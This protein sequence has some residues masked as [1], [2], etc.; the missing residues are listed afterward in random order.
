MGLFRLFKY[1]YLL[2]NRRKR[3]ASLALSIALAHASV[4]QA[5]Y[6]SIG[7]G[8]AD[9]TLSLDKD[10]KFHLDLNDFAQHKRYKMA[11]KWSIENDY[12][13]LTFKKAK[14]DL[15][16]LFTGSTG[17]KTYAEIA[18]KRTVKFPHTRSGLMINGVYCLRLV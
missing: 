12:Y 13:I 7:N 14:K 17:F 8:L 10:Q 2:N 5:K 18:N 1:K 15:S 9:I 6:K 4:G 16:E 3:Y 11:G